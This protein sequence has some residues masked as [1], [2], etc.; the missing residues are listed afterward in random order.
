MDGDARQ[1][2]QTKKRGQNEEAERE[3]DTD[4]WGERWWGRGR[5]GDYNFGT[6][7]AIRLR[8]S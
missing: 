4:R 3:K 6:V 8:N 2:A 7:I 1:R 5:G